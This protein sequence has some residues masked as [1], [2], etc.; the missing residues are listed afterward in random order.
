VGFANHVRRQL[1]ESLSEGQ[2]SQLRGEVSAFVRKVDGILV[3]R[4]ARIGMLPSPTRRAYQFLTN[5]DL[6]S[7]ETVQS[8]HPAVAPRRVSGT[9]RMDGMQTYWRSLLRH[10]ALQSEDDDMEKLHHEIQSSSKEVERYLEDQSL[11]ANDLT[12]SSK[13]IRGWLAYFA[14]RANFDAYVAAIQR[15]RPLFNEKLAGAS[16]FRAPAIIEFQPVAALYKLSGRRHDTRVILPTPMIVFSSELFAHLAESAL[17]RGGRQSVMNA[18]VTNEYKAVQRDLDSLIGAEEST[19]GVYQ[20]LESAFKRVNEKYFEG[21]MPRP[22]L[23]WNRAFTGRKFGHYDFIRDTIMISCSLDQSVIPQFVLDF[24]VYH[25]LLHKKLGLD[26][27]NGRAAAH[28]REFRAQ[29][30]LFERYAEADAALKQIA[31]H[32]GPTQSGNGR[33]QRAQH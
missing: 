20:D 25:E 32:P 5:L 19:R 33:R 14:C 24:V 29:E 27:R 15:A 18:T 17:A 12:I 13:N 10:L 1:S 16:R 7:V 23:T 6:D 30:R 9:V 31:G 2:L 8:H 26:W 28:T 21:N 4:N 11:T 22:R 3:V